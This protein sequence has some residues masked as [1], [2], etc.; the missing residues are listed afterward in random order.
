MYIF[1][2]HNFMNQ[3]L[4]KLK[5]ETCMDNPHLD[6]QECTV[7]SSTQIFTSLIFHFQEGNTL[8]LVGSFV[9]VLTEITHV[10]LHSLLH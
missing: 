6:N 10:N 2:V 4:C 3:I 7:H 5:K 1:I 9:I 8:L